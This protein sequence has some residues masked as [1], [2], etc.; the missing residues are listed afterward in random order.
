MIHPFTRGFH[1]GKS[2]IVI[3]PESDHPLPGGWEGGRV[4]FQAAQALMSALH[5]ATSFRAR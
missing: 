5:T 1:W 4:A 3:Q 2:T